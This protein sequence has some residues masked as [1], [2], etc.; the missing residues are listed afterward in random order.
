MGWGSLK[1]L[2]G[3][4][5]SCLRDVPLEEESVRRKRW[6]GG[7]WLG[8][9]KKSQAR[10]H[11]KEANGARCRLAGFGLGIDG[12]PD[13]DMS[14]RFTFCF[15]PSSSSQGVRGGMGRRTP[16]AAATELR[17]PA[18][19]RRAES[20]RKA[21][22]KYYNT[23][24]CDARATVSGGRPGQPR[25]QL[26]SARAMEKLRRRRWDPP[27]GGQ[28]PAP[29]PEP[30][31][32]LPIPLPRN[33]PENEAR[34]ILQDHRKKMERRAAE[35]EAH[36]AR[37]SKKTRKKSGWA[38]DERAAALDAYRQQKAEAA[39]S[40]QG[41]ADEHARSDALDP[42]HVNSL[43]QINADATDES[44]RREDEVDVALTI[45]ALAGESP[46]DQDMGSVGEE[47]RA[48][49]SERTAPIGMVAGLQSDPQ[50]DLSG[51]E[52]DG[53]GVD[54]SKQ[55]RGGLDFGEGAA[56]DISLVRLYF[57]PRFICLT[58]IRFEEHA[59]GNANDHGLG[60]RT[61]GSTLLDGGP[62]AWVY[63]VQAKVAE[64]NSGD[65]SEPTLMEAMMWQEVSPV[66]TEAWL[67][68][69]SAG[70]AQVR[71]WRAG[72][73]PENEWDASTARRM[74][75]LAVQIPVDRMVD[76]I[77]RRLWED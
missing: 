6:I 33:V 67:P 50:V 28:L 42:L 64:L 62:S 63:E 19:E 23:R 8:N 59:R 31:E 22:K 9:N 30:S 21:Y 54:R 29:S 27:K 56:A 34:Q 74:A 20:N 7:V 17:S 77:E 72:L 4:G 25:R 15:L 71:A 49:S 76:Q 3:Y 38:P 36:R 73:A 55:H 47:T 11:K 16:K 37:H 52:T 12:T 26:I 13:G 53:F 32:I 41:M 48:P 18:A 2:T 40:F 69:S 35:I 70:L 14:W 75:Q 61:L 68:I 46:L 24:D 66:E 58:V 39:A 65:L 60:F 57:V 44:K 5:N 10:V 45:L 51:E 43:L 1:S